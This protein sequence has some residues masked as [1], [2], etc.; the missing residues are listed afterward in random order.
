MGSQ[1]VKEGLVKT[2]SPPAYDGCIEEK[3]DDVVLG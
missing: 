1:K 3:S 2:V